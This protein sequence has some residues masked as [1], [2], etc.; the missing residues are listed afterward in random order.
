MRRYLFSI[1]WVNS[2]GQENLVHTTNILQVKPLLILYENA[3]SYLKAENNFLLSTMTYLLQLPH[4]SH[5]PLFEILENWF[6]SLHANWV[7]ANRYRDNLLWLMC[8]LDRRLN[9]ARIVKDSFQY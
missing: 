4:Q 2:Q 6:E 9:L 5:G 8:L 3:R 7:L 1:S